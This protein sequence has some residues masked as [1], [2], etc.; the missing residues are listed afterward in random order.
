MNNDDV[1]LH[2]PK[3]PAILIVEYFRLPVYGAFLMRNIHDL[4]FPEL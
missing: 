2:L 3:N 1:K 4:S